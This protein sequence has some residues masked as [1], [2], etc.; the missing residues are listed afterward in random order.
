MRSKYPSSSAYP[1]QPLS[2]RSRYNA[3]SSSR[4]SEMSDAAREVTPPVSME[5]SPSKPEVRSGIFSFARKHCYSRYMFL[6]SLICQQPQENN[7]DIVKKEE[8]KLRA[9][10]PQA[11]QGPHGGHTAF[12]QKRL[13][14]GV[15]HS[16]DQCVFE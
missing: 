5:T 11:A 14:K 7:E 6:F 3:D 13:A 1:Q 15:R 9:K 16:N 12:I 2:K 4:S 10:Y 8:E